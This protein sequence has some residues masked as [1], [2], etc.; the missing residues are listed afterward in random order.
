MCIRD[1]C[2][3][4]R[5]MEQ[6][7]DSACSFERIYF[8]RG[9]DKDIY[10]AVSY[11]HLDGN[12]LLLAAGKLVWQVFELI[13]QTHLFQH[14]LGQLVALGAGDIRV[15]QRQMCIR[16]SLCHLCLS[17]RAHLDRSGQRHR[18]RHQCAGGRRGLQG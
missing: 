11:T 13:P 15:D 6:K 10:K 1:R 2:S 17:G 7:G 8:S 5:I 14:I 3:I 4:E 18:F 12:A 9:S 16:D